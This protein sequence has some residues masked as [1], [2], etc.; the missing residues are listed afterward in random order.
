LDMTSVEIT[1]VGFSDDRSATRTISQTLVTLNPLPNAPQNPVVTRGSFII[2]GSATIH[3]PEG[4]STIWSGGAVDLGSN[5]STHSADVIENDPAL[6]SLSSEDFFLH[7]FGISP[8]T[9]RASMVTIDTTPADFNS[10]A[11]LA[12]HEVIWVEGDTTVQGNT[13]GCTTSVGGNNVCPTNHQKPTIIIIDGNA[14]L[15]GT[16]HVY[17]MLFVTGTM[18]VSGSATVH[19]AA[20]AAVTSVN[21]GG[22]LDVR[23]NSSILA[24]SAVAGN[25]TGSAGSWKDF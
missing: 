17:G 5:N 11:E 6:G 4:H 10:D 9:Y 3:S 1:A 2:G 24:G 25:S 22:S 13:I 19:G 7:F 14:T 15:T 23:F 20:V 21:A 8:S 16:P 18:S 12:T